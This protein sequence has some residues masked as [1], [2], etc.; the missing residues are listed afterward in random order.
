MDSV[1]G[2]GTKI[3]RKV[4]LDGQKEKK[5]KFI[6][7]FWKLIVLSVFLYGS[8]L[9]GGFLL[10]WEENRSNDDFQKLFIQY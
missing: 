5:K 3:P 6:R 9:I 7:L 1:P 2:Q 8:W 10:L 4:M